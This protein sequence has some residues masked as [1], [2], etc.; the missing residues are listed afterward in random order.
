[1]SR[2]LGT[3]LAAT[4]AAVLA[5]G[6]ISLPAQASPYSALYAFGDSLSD[7]GRVFALTGTPPAPY[8]NGHYSNGLVG[9]EYLAQGM[10]IG[11]TSYAWGG[12]TTGQL[13]SNAA[14]N[15]VLPTGV[16]AQVAEFGAAHGGVADPNA[17]YFVMAGPN[18][19]FSLLSSGASLPQLQ[20]AAQ[21]AVGNLVTGVSTLY[22][23]GARNFLLPLMPDLGA[24]VGATKADAV[25]PGSAA[26]ASMF[27]AMFNA[28][29]AGAY[30]QLG[31]M[32]AG[33]QLFVVD[34]LAVHHAALAQF[35]QGASA[36]CLDDLAFPACT[37]YMFFDDVHPTTE[38]H[39]LFAQAFA[40]AVPEPASWMIGGIALLAAGAATRRRQR[41]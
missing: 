4:A 18:D 5:L 35:A 7:T 29:L 36:S 30:G 13:N 8:F 26:G 2:S 31:G 21:T 11:L 23:M 6:A 19:F 40:N 38:A 33:E 1:M 41:G 20:A 10:G 39:R 3:R 27:S 28:G 25:V 12:A 14:L 32:L 17:L 34:T 9:V 24:T 22:G 15:A 16:L 37:G